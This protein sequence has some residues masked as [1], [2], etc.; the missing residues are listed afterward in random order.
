GDGASRAEAGADGLA[1]RRAKVR[2]VLVGARRRRATERIGRPISTNLDA[3][4]PNEQRV[5]RVEREDAAEQRPPPLVELVE[6]HQGDGA[7]VDVRARPGER[8]QRA[9]VRRAHEAPRLVAVVQRADAEA[10]AREEERGA[11]AIPDREREV[12]EEMLGTGRTP[13]LVR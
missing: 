6:H 8:E 11:R 4:G 13:S 10:V 7:L 12:A 3:V 2:R 5:R 1:E 9:L